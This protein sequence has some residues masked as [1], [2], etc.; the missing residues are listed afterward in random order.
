MVSFQLYCVKFCVTGLKLNNGLSKF[1]SI[2]NFF[3]KHFS[4]PY[5]WGPKRR[6]MPLFND[7]IFLKCNYAL[8]NY[9]HLEIFASCRWL[10]SWTN[11]FNGIR[12]SSHY[13]INEVI[14]DFAIFGGPKRRQNTVLKKTEKIKK[15]KK[16]KSFFGWKLYPC[17]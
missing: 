5:T 17:A 3:V 15:P 11:F 2:F 16:Q 10:R 1:C 9:F 12:L 14:N 6:Q 4:I 13:V 7:R 8:K